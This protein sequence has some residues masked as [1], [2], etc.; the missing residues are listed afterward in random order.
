MESSLDA[1]YFSSGVLTRLKIPSLENEKREAKQ[2]YNSSQKAYV[3]F[4]LGRP[5]EKLNVRDKL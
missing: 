2:K 3:T 4:M 1:K 5:M